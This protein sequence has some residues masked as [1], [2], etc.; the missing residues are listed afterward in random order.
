MTRI[1]K[2]E[3]INTNDEMFHELER[4]IEKDTG[5]KIDYMKVVGEQK[6]ELHIM[7]YFTDRK[8]CLMVVTTDK[9]GKDLI[10]RIKG[11]Y[12]N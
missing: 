2:F 1:Y 4:T 3:G 7:C 5:R 12:L 11:R 6:E 9:I 8:V 10:F